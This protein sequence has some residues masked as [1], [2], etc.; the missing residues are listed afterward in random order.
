MEGFTMNVYVW[1]RLNKIGS[2]SIGAGVVVVAK[3]LEIARR[4][5][6]ISAHDAHTD[7]DT[8]FD[9]QNT[10]PT[11][12]IE[13]A[14]FDEVQEVF[15]FPDPSPDPLN[16]NFNALDAMWLSVGNHRLQQS[17]EPMTSRESPAL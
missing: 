13:A 7:A 6:P 5:M 2:D 3:S 1:Q 12:V 8:D 9:I 10:P 16:L 4:M 14:N 15:L 17:L 11:R